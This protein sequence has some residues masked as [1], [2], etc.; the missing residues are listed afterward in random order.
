MWYY[1]N[2][3]IDSIE[4]MPKNTWGFIYKITNIDNNKFYIGKKQ[5]YN[6]NNVKIG[7]KEK[8]QITGKGRRPCK[9]IIIKESNWL[10]YYGSNKSL[11]ED[12]KNLG[13]SAF[14]REILEFA[15]NK[16]Q[17]TYLEIK[18]QILNDVLEKDNSY[19]DNIL[20]KFFKNDVK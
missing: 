5:L 17:L 15:F 12:I 1:K 16:K 14:K 7:K 13:E 9:K 2:Q 11:L 4:Q 8:Q 18:Y 6:K 10:L 20:G 19:N 3:I